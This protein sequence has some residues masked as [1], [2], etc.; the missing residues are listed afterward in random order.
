MNLKTLR[1][2]P[3]AEGR[4]GALFFGATTAAGLGALALLANVSPEEPGHYPT[5][6]FLMISG[7][8]CPGCG[9]L[10]ATHALLHGDLATAWDRNPLAFVLLPVVAISWVAWG[11][12]LL[13][14]NAWHP[15]R[16]HPG[17]IWGLLTVVLIY[18]IARN[19]PGWTLLSPL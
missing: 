9:S 10:R 18:W 2:V 6:P 19:V 11:L 3:T 17:W 12:R 16:V 14:Y 4:R 13:G 8:Y 5:C 15:T 1:P 7:L